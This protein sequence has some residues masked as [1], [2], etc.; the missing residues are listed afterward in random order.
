ME[1]AQEKRTWESPPVAV[2]VGVFF[3]LF[4]LYVWLVIDPRLVY[5]SIGITTYYYPFSFHS[6]WPFL[7]E[8]LARP[9]GLAEYG[10]RLLTQFYCF[11]WAGGLIVSA[12]A[13]CLYFC[14]AVVTRCAGRLQCDF[15]HYVPAVLLLVMYGAYG[16]PLG[17]VLS[18]LTG[19]LGFVLYVRLAP[20]TMAGRLPVLVLACA[21]FYQIAGAGSLL[22][23][24]MAGVYELLVAGR[25]FLAAAAWLCA[26]GVPWAMGTL[27]GLDSLNT[28]SD[29]VI[30]GAGVGVGRWPYV[31]ALFFPALLAATATWSAMAGR[32]ASRPPKG[33]SRKRGSSP[34]REASRLVWQGRLS[35]FLPTAAVFLATGTA[36]W[37]SFDS[38]GRTV[39]EIDYY[40]EREQWPEV[41]KAADRLPRGGC[42]GRSHRNIMLALYQTGQLG[43]RMFRYTQPPVDDLFRTP[44][45]SRDVGTHYQESRLY[46]DLGLV[47]L[48]EKSAYEALETCGDLPA[49]LEELAI[50]NL[51]KGRPET[52]GIFLS[53][54]AQHPLY[55]RAARD[56]QRRVEADPSLEDD[57][58]VAIIR[59]NM[60]D[61]DSVSRATTVE[62]LLLA[63]LEKNPHN[64]MA[65]E[66]LMAY[67]LSAGRPEQ[68]AARL[69]RLKD[70]SYPRI[71]R[72]FQ[73]AMAMCAF[74]RGG[75]SPISG[76]A[77]DPEVLRQSK[78]FLQILAR[79]P[80]R[81]GALRAALA[82]GFGDSYFFYFTFHVSGL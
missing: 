21:A 70:F 59:R 43:D 48:A 57:P 27:F 45:G 41:L 8:H 3:L 19:L 74:V 77:I 63:L 53:A 55:S 72:H 38:F 56:M 39:R 35:R 29:L 34:S 40:S 60:L 64:Q 50:V 18:L 13:W 14:T 15:F 17:P 31:L 58:R 25:V 42:D 75:Q 1:V 7:E 4:Y 73:E 10:T 47:N 36:A 81:E 82:A 79:V 67:T 26:L 71:P 65:F 2:D 6:G 68:I 52:A 30:F 20:Q 5:Q 62:D 12:V 32:R 80:S 28:Y 44:V 22:F 9:G 16:H 69:E 24:V 37:F 33:R 66:F 61:K 11:G 49:V 76:Y 54:L 23:P 46:L 51:V 78:A